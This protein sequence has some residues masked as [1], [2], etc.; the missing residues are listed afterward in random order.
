MVLATTIGGLA[1]QAPAAATLTIQADQPGAIISSNLFGIFFEEINFAGDG[2][3][4]AEMVSNRNFEPPS[5]TAGWQL[6][7]T[8]SA[9][10]TSSSDSSM[11]LNASNLYSAK[12]NF[13]SGSGGVG[14]ANNGYWGMNFQAGQTYQLGLYARCSSG[15]N[16]TL[17]AGL[18]SANGSRI[19]A[20]GTLTGLTTNWQYFSLTLV[21]NATDTA[22][23]LALVISQ[24]G[25]VWL[26]VVSL[27]PGATFDNRTNG[28]RSDL[29]SMLSALH[30]SFLRFPG[31]NFIEGANITNAVRWKKTIGDISQRPGH[32][33]DAWGYWSTDGFG[34]H[35]F[36]QFCEDLGMQPLYAVNGGLA[37]GYNGSSNNT[38]P[39]S[40]MG[41]W[42]QDALDAIQYAN[43]DTNTTW[44]ALRAA[45]GHPAPFNL[46]YLEI[47][48]ENGGSY[49]D[50]R[51]TLFYDAIKSNYPSL[52]LI[53]PGNWPGGPPWSRPVEIQ[54]EHYYASPATF[55]SYATKYDSYR[56]NGPK[57]FV[58]EYAVNSSYG[59]YGNLASALAE[60]AFMTGLERNSD[61]VQMAS[62]APLLAN[63]NGYQWL[64]DLIY[65]DSARGIFG[66]PSY[67]VQEL[68]GQNRGDVV[69]PTVISGT[70]SLYASSSL[71]QS[72]GQII[73]KVVNTNSTP[74]ATTFNVTGVNGVASGATV[75]QLTSGSLT[76]GNSLTLP[77]KVFPITNSIANAGTNFT[78]TLPANSLSILRLTASGINSYTNLLLQFTSPIARGQQVAATVSGQE[79][80]NW[81]NLTTNANHAITYT[82]ADTNVA[83]V[84]SQGNITGMGP[85]TTSIMA[86]YASLGLSAT[87][88]LQVVFAPTTLVHRYSFN[89]GTAND[90]VGSANGTLVGNASISG[91]QL[92]LPNTTSV[93][94]AADYLQL[95]AGILANSVNG[96]NN[97]PAV[98]VEAWATIKAGQYTWANLFDFGN[99]DAGGL[100]EYDLHVCVHA[101]DNSTIAGISDSDNA[102]VDYQYI[103]LGSGSSLDGN[104]N[105]HIT[106]V[107]NPPAGY[108]AVYLN[109]VLAGANYNVTIPMSGVQAVRNIIGADN[110]PD[111][112]MQGSIDE[113]RIYN[114]ALTTNKIA[115]T[116]VLGPNQLLNTASPAVSAFAS[117]GSLT[118]SWP[119]ASADYTVV[120]T[121]NLAAGNWVAAAVTPQIVGNQWQVV[122][123]ITGNTQF[124]RLMQQ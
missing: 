33:D 89:D 92:V 102:N 44:G 123:P 21:P 113:F 95:P 57:V 87:Q 88:S 22:G 72:N 24:S 12:L 38:V 55:Y 67:Y 28:L 79:S 36:L 16:G 119:V 41:P 91:G 54:D 26:D 15:Y 116:Q 106:A 112:G 31:G 20:Q 71:L 14:L 51:Y 96:T 78:F 34:Y 109:G 45:N 25:S 90:S 4:Y 98:T 94:P 73:V 2:G 86:T 103:D 52:H 19:Y 30:P 105:V 59:T 8:G 32:L 37:L 56:R 3:I 124:Y 111:P 83:V 117:A 5:L 27:F 63:L 110:W 13:S 74:L 104:T 101:N 85:G 49:Y 46:Q 100:S 10:G 115:A 1:A 23:R 69:L 66:A 108:V 118:L 84:D 121:T 50:D 62:Y 97:D 48:N 82:S 17:I 47:G 75:I 65:Y 68:F 64:P 76:D 43:G 114:G 99:R 80:G 61:I 60:A 42:V 39:L 7:T 53:A 70:T 6:I 40:Q 18:E 29:A 120:T 11:P 122:L 9:V 81:L 93:A 77:T 58:G 107:F 35:E